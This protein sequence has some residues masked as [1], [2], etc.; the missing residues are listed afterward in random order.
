VAGVTPATFAATLT[1]L[2]ASQF[3]IQLIYLDPQPTADQRAKFEAARDRWQSIIV[4]DITDFPGNFPVNACGD[5]IPSPAVTGPIDDVAILAGVRG[6][7]GAGQILAQAGPCYVRDAGKLTI[8][9][10]VSFDDADLATLEALPGGLADVAFHEMG[11]VLGFGTLWS[12]LGVIQFP[13]TENVVFT[14]TAGKQG[15]AH[16][17]NQGNP[18]PATFNVPVENCVGIAGCGE[19]T[20]DGHWREP[21]FGAEIM[22]GYYNIA[23]VPNPFSAMSAAAMRDLNYVVNDAAS[24]AFTLPLVL[25]R[26]R[27]GTGERVFRERLAPW[28]IRIVDQAGTVV[29]EARR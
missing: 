18:P 9:G 17:L 19:G 1:P 11:H 10:V 27:L 28:P 21:V 6:I 12:D 20:Q 14:G 7:D 4:G 16:I 24:Q 13:G 29:G 8:L 5:D 2:P 25:S 3:N 23:V 15:Y 22:T 26:L